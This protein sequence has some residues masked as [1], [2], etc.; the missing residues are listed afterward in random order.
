MRPLGHL[1]VALLLAGC[2]SAGGD[3]LT[4]PGYTPRITLKTWLY[5]PPGPG[6][7][8]AV[9]VLHGCDGVNSKYLEW[10]ARLAA[11]GYI[12]L[13]VDS[14][15]PRGYSSICAAPTRSLPFGVADRA[16]DAAAA[17]RYLATRS[18][19]RADRI[20]LVG[21]S[22]GGWTISYLAG[23]HLGTA[24]AAAVAWCEPARQLAF[25]LLIL[26]GDQDDT[27]PPER[28]RLLE[29]YTET[30]DRLTAVYYRGATHAFDNPRHQDVYVPVVGAGGVQARRLSY[31]IS[32]TNDAQR[33]TREWLD[34]YL[35]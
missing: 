17:V 7:F 25:P 9:L 16:L 23:S 11:W 27:T 34:R 10:G 3:F 13:V 30:K 14:L 22:G 33:R 8:P 18:D 5:R 19:V 32:A 29:S 12:A 15:G 4:I 21:F 1:F 35:K 6:P 2:A 31:D 24:F 28:C 26:I 20:G